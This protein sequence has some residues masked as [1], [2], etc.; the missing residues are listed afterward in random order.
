MHLLNLSHR[1]VRSL[2]QIAGIV[3]PPILS[4]HSLLKR[5]PFT[6][7]TG[8][9]VAFCSYLLLGPVPS[10]SD[11]ISASL[12]LGLITVLALISVTTIVHGLRMKKRLSAELI[13]PDEMIVSLQQAQCILH[14]SAFKLLPG[15]FLDCSI[16]F[17]NSVETV[18]TVRLYGSSR[19]DRRIVVHISF[20]HR[21]NWD[22]EGID[23][24]LGDSAGCV[25]LRWRIPL[26]SSII[27]APPIP[28]NS[29]LPLVSS[30]QRPGDL[31]PDAVHRLGDPFDIKPYHPSDGIKKIVWKAFAKSGELLARHPEPSMTPEG[32][33][34]I[35][36]V[37]RPQDDDLCGKALSYIAALKELT[38][39]LLVACQGHNGRPLGHDAETSKTLL[40]DSVWDAAQADSTLLETDFQALID[41]CSASSSQV[42][43]RKMVVFCSGSRLTDPAEANTIVRIATWLDAH[44]I[45]PVFFLTQPQ[46][47]TPDSPPSRL[48]VKA[49]A[50]FLE[51]DVHTP[52]AHSAS[53]YQNFLS[54]CLSKQWEVFL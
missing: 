29:T 42:Q 12:A 14:L 46:S 33:V 38:L 19:T 16:A 10:S 40:I 23:C 18:S 37:A 7:Q 54:T 8:L 34:A 30:T 20:P 22:I 2:S 9:L 24:S 45:E 6:L 47:L 39:D 1:F 41:A 44:S 5:T 32:F 48:A 52:Q 36:V 51:P 26:Q 17:S 50:I 13:S 21:G 43:L 53:N 15:T 27:V 4:F 11:I 49:Q 28:A 3:R 31:A 25:R 35:C